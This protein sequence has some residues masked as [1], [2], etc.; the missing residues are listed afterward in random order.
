MNKNQ[1]FKQFL[2]NPLLK[3]KLEIEEKI[4]KEIDLQT[5]VERYPLIEIIKTAVMNLEDRETIDV[6]T[7]RINQS[8]KR[9]DL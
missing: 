6:A 9:I 7:R 3:E 4:L 1:I 2:Q 5:D 8:L